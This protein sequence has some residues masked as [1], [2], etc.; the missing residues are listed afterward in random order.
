M[1][2]NIIIILAGTYLLLGAILYFLQSKFVFNPRHHLFATPNNF[3]INFEEVWLQTEDDV[4][5]HAWFIP[6][7]G[8]KYTVLFCHGNGGCLSHRVE[9]IELYHKLG[10]NFLIFDYRGYGLSQGKISERGLFADAEAA[11]QYLTKTKNIKPENIVIIGRSL[12]AAVATRLAGEKHPAKLICESAFLSIPEMAKELYPYYPAA[13]LSRYSFST[14]T[15][16]KNIRCPVLFVHSRDDE[17]VKFRHGEQLFTLAGEP[18][19]FLELSG[20]HDECYFDNRQK[21]TAAIKK[22]IDGE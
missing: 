19:Q 2:L 20:G 6:A 14:K 3:G 12:G 11:W 13:L 10:Y 5:I 17:V 16:L 7:A 15:Y 9:T 1:L 22:F 4:K 21:Y 8:A 18:K